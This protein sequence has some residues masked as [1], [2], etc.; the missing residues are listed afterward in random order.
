[1]DQVLDHLSQFA[2][3]RWYVLV[4]AVILLAVIIK[5]VKTVVKWVLVIAI[6]AGV[7][8]YGANY[9]EM[10]SDVGGQVMDFVKEEALEVMVGEA[11]Q[12][13]FRQLGDGA[14]EVRS[15]NVTITGDS[16]SDKVKIEFKGY[17]FEIDMNDAI[18]TYIERARANGNG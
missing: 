16:G 13:E 17:S 14:Y 18:R 5:V 10:I 3:D 8:Y 2:Q 15:R 9:T 1:M 6:A 4:V 11:A 12:A 7:I